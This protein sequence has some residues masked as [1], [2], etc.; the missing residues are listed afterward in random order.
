MATSSTAGF[1]NVLDTIANEVGIEVNDLTDGAKVADLGVDSLLTISILG[2]LRTET[3]LD[4][5]RSL[6]I[7]YPTVSELKSFFSDKSG[8]T[9][10]IPEHTPIHTPREYAE[11]TH[12]S[13]PSSFAP[14]YAT[15]ADSE[16][17]SAVSTPPEAEAPDSVA[18]LKT[19]I[20]H[21]VGID[22]SEIL[23]STP[24]AE[25]GV[26]SLLTISILDAFKT[27]LGFDLPAM[28][29]QQYPTISDVQKI[30]GSP[31]PSPKQVLPSPPAAIHTSTSSQSL[32]ESMTHRAKTV[33]LQGRPTPGR[34]NLFLL[35]DGAG[36][37]FSYISL[38]T[39]PSGIPV[40]GLDS[41]FHNNPQ[42]Y[43]MSFSDVAKIYIEA[44]R[45]IQPRG[46]Y[47]LGGWSLGGIHAYET[48]RQLIEQGERVTHLL[49]IDSPCPGTLP[50]LP[51]PTLNLIEI[52]VIF[53]GLSSS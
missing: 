20:A 15:S 49:M 5:P 23:P 42:E 19:I 18:I 9:N 27:Q 37:L 25:I 43:T 2:K 10:P 35:P 7:T 24:F 32:P 50:P 3:N 14:S 51:S 26:D 47:M 39:L 17:S 28:F 45:A 52:A 1:A 6:F 13:Y 21:E 36:S 44:I 22:V 31:K 40:Y 41:P 29:F 16:T 8:T 33:L 11:S 30:L 48:S 38:P 46:P 4:L 53:Q 12:S 34:Q